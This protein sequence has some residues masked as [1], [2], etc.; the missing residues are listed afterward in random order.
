MRRSS[1]CGILQLR[2]DYDMMLLLSAVVSISESI[3][4]TQRLEHENQTLVRS[5]RAIENESRLAATEAKR[6]KEELQE[7]K[8][9]HRGVHVDKLSVERK[10]AELNAERSRLE[11]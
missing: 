7:E 3:E 11:V 2:R 5:L 1:L 6:L 9:K 10:V 4:R 8:K